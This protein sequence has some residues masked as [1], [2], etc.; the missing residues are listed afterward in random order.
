MAR[1]QKLETA[2]NRIVKAGDTVYFYSY[3]G[4]KVRTVCDVGYGPFVPDTQFDRIYGTREGAL[5]ARIQYL[6]ESIK[7]ESKELEELK[8][9]GS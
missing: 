7:T 6:E 5:L 3:R 1:Q 9:L 4:L 2:D 8:K